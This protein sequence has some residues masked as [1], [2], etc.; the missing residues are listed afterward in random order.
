MSRSKENRPII[1]FGDSLVEGIG[2]SE[3]NDWVSILTARYQIP[4]LNRG[5]SHDTTRSAK[6]RL[7]EDVL[8]Q[9]PRLVVLLLGGNDVLVRI[10]KKETFSNFRIMIDRIHEQRTEV[11]LIGVRGGISVDAFE[12]KFQALA[13]DTGTH[14]IP[15]ILEGILGDPKLMADPLHPNDEGY[16]I[17]AERIGPVL[18]NVIS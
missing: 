8:Q 14:F 2:A 6:A 7:E 9:D 15:D 5:K 18:I 17:M 1:A 3:G 11:L 12:G 10:P 4:L 13:E 16:R